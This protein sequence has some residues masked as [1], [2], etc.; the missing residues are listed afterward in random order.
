M[1]HQRVLVEHRGT[2]Y[3][4]SYSLT[5]SVLTVTT[6]QFGYLSTDS[7]RGSVLFQAAQL[8][9]RIILMAEAEGRLPARH[10][11]SERARDLWHLKSS[12]LVDV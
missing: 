12:Q 2:L 11:S 5:D 6:D 8:L 4:G 7:G 10:E 9:G 3:V 1:E